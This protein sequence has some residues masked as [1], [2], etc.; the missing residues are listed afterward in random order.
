MWNLGTQA[1]TAA[2]S[3]RARLQRELDA[4]ELAK[5]QLAQKETEVHTTRCPLHHLL[6]GF[7]PVDLTPLTD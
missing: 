6:H 5:A 1:E 4:H 7:G 2:A 3:E